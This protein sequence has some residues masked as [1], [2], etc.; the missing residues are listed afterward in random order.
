MYQCTRKQN[1]TT[2]RCNHYRVNVELEFSLAISNLPVGTRVCKINASQLYT[3]TDECYYTAVKMSASRKTMVSET[4]VLR[5]LVSEPS[6]TNIFLKLS[7]LV[8]CIRKIERIKG[9]HVYV[10]STCAVRCFVRAMLS[11]LFSLF[12][13]KL[14]S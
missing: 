5:S 13:T 4:Q 12:S 11:V 7:L 3:I 9:V 1:A 14:I 2:V 6:Q 10:Y 8:V